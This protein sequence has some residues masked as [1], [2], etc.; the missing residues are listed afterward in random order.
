MDENREN[1]LIVVSGGLAVYTPAKDGDFD[2]VFQRADR[3]MYERKSTL[4]GYC[5]V[6]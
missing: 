4:K 5:N 2:S 6:F 1:G 3:K